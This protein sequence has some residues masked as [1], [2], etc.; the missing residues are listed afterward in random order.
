MAEN[1]AQTDLRD[2]RKWAKLVG[3]AKGERSVP[4][5]EDQAR[6]GCVNRGEIRSPHFH[7]RQKSTGESGAGILSLP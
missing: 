4:V 7:R 5:E 1:R 2:F 3:E 6:F